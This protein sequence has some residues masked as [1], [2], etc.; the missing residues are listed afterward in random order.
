MRFQVHCLR[1]AVWNFLNLREKFHLSIAIFVLYSFFYLQSILRNQKTIISLTITCHSIS[2]FHANV[3]KREP[4]SYFWTKLRPKG[5]EKFFRDTG[6][7]LISRSGSGTATGS[8]KY[9]VTRKNILRYCTLNCPIRYTAVYILTVHFAKQKGVSNI[10]GVFIMST[11]LALWPE[12]NLL[13]LSQ[14]QGVH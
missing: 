1:V 4:Q 10:T 9:N 14:F 12:L 5:P 3:W 6:H 13:G 8:P 11:R 7:P 2:V